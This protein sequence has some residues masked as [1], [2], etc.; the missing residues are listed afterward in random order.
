MFTTQ[1]QTLKTLAH[2]NNS[3]FFKN[4]DPTIDNPSLGDLLEY[5]LMVMEKFYKVLEKHFPPVC[6]EEEPID[7]TQFYRRFEKVSASFPNENLQ[8]LAVDCCD[9]ILPILQNLHKN[10]LSPFPQDHWKWQ[11]WNQIFTLEEMEITKAADF[12]RQNP[13]IYET[14]LTIQTIFHIMESAMDYFKMLTKERSVLF[15][16]LSSLDILKSLSRISDYCLRAERARE[17]AKPLLEQVDAI[18]NQFRLASPPSM[19]SRPQ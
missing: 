14:F 7:W 4:A 2:S 13:N 8:K 1:I 17:I 18:A 12:A 9:V 10:T 16:S 3:L 5:F 11:Y 19:E 6:D 15:P